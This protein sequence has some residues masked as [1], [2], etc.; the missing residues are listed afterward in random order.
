MD[1]L[2]DAVCPL[3]LRDHDDEALEIGQRPPLLNGGTP[4]SVTRLLPLLNDSLLLKLLLDDTSTGG[5]GKLREAE[6]G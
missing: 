2:A 6:R 3:L 1:S 5:A 4:L